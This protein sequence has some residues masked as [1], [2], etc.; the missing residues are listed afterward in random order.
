MN[1]RVL[2]IDDE[3]KLRRLLS[4][5][6]KSENY[7]VIEAESGLHGVQLAARFQPEAIILDL[8]LPDLDGQEVLLQLREFTDSPVIVLSVRDADSEKVRGLDNGAQDYV[9]KPFSVEE[10]LAR[11]RVCLRDHQ[12][13]RSVASRISDG[14]LSIDF[15]SRQVTIQNTKVDLTPK[16]YAVLITLAKAPNKVVTQE[17]LLSQIWGKTHVDDTHYL[18]IVVSH[19]RRKLNDP[20]QA[21]HYLITIPSVGYQ[22]N[23]KQ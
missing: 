18:R 9:T 21:P 7:Q 11:L 20:P 23:I 1:E 6:L 19:L 14:N 4:I 13:S 17:F 3:P 22:L 8:G 5:T 16:E 10:L 2:V 15:A 12:P